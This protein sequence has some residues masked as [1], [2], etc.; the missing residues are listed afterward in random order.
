[1]EVFVLSRACR[2]VQ[3]MFAVVALAESL[4]NMSIA[5]KI[6]GLPG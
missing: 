5:S 3:K 1:M 6:H 2:Q 4:S